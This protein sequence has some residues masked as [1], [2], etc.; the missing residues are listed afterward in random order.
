MPLPVPPIELA[1]RVGGAV[2]DA[3]LTI[4]AKH[5]Q[6]IESMLPPDWSWRER[7]ILDFGCGAGRTIRHFCDDSGRPE[8]WGC[9]IHEPSIR[10][11][12]ENLSPPVNAFVNGDAPPLPMAD[13]FFDVVYGMSV[14]THITTEWSAWLLELHRV[15]KDGGY[16]IA[17]FLGEGMSQQIAREPWDESRIG[18]NV[19]TYGQAWD[20]GGP[21]VLLS[22][23]WIRAHWGR[24]FEIVD[25]RP[26][27][28]GGHGFVVGRKK[29]VTLTREELER[30]KPDEPRE[31]AA[32][33]HQI[34]QLL[35]EGAIL[36]H[37]IE[38][39]E[40]QLAERGA[41][42]TTALQECDGLRQ[43]LAAVEGSK[44]WSLT[45]PLRAARQLIRR[46]GG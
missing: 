44:S 25:L 13:R 28:E 8:L 45:K 21:N 5:R 18:M 14:F 20:K 42:R 29:A 26:G 32:Q 31:D 40:E 12:Q 34:R 4:G 3:Y 39:L 11:L 2:G 46:G 37:Y 9:D 17:S 27:S 22:P 10:W 7:R 36:R 16:L 38:A 6:W 33:R 41:Q 15:L 1:E 43:R 24:V 35:N 23:W 19:M 30:P